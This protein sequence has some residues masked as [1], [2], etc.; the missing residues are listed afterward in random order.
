MKA[1]CFSGDH[2]DFFMSLCD[3]IT[4]HLV[5]TTLVIHNYGRDVFT[6][7]ITICHHGRNT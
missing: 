3:Q 2:S 1:V 7:R 4:D 6:L 5:C